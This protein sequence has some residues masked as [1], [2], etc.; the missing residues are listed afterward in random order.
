LPT[1]SE[2][3]LLYNNIGQNAIAPFT[4]IGNFGNFSYWS[5]TLDFSSAWKQEFRQIIIN[6]YT[7]GILS[8]VSQ[9][10]LLKVRAIRAF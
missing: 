3:K 1:K 5:A 4:N 6:F 2:I 10:S 7:E 9:S 8:S